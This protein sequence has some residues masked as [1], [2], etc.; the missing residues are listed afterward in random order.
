M[1]DQRAVICAAEA[2]KAL[3]GAAIM[4]PERAVEL[5]DSVGFDQSAMILEVPRHIVGFVRAGVGRREAVDFV[6]IATSVSA[7]FPGFRPGELTALCEHVGDG[8]RVPSWCAAVRAAAL[9]REAIAFT[10]DQLDLLRGTGD[11]LEVFETTKGWLQA[12]Q[13]AL[14]PTR[15]AML[16]DLIAERLE[17]YSEPEDQSRIIRTG[18]ASLDDRMTIEAS[19]VL[20]IGGATGSGK[21]MLGLNL[22][23]NI[24]RAA[25][26]SSGLIVS[27]EM[28]A[29][30]VTERIIARQ[31]S[32]PTHR[33]KQRQYTAADI[34]RI[35]QA[36]V[37][38]SS[39]PLVIRDDC[40]SLTQV[41]AAARSIHANRPLRVIMV[42]YLQLV[43]GPDV[44]LREQQVAAVSR[45]LRLLALET[46]ALVIALAQLNK[47]GEAR[48]S[49][50][51]M[52][53]ATQFVSIR[54][55]D[56]EGK[57]YSAHDDEAEIDDTRRRINIG[58][59]RDGGTGS[60][61][62][63][64]DGARASFH[65]IDQP[66]KKVANGKRWHD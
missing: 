51:I 25:P 48:E 52:M 19:D 44:E 5:L 49:A 9:R 24:L 55:V 60:V 37:D 59:Q 54:L 58:K 38:L 43:R 12:K 15:S 27:L 29:A 57:P 13:R 50:A 7:M 56:T 40:Q 53:D 28:T 46:G 2:E 35:Q 17:A 31:A 8:S 30:Q 41:T 39:L 6:G 45:E 32:V 62:V 22:V 42:D 61:L 33:L 14:A 18:I 16:R 11:I 20:V 34:S 21:S 10:S 26:E 65:D 36:A 47:Q 63:G 66:E 3:A 23:L 4:M 1:R 64:F